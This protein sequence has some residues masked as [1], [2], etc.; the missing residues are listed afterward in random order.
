[1]KN[2][3]KRESFNKLTQNTKDALSIFEKEIR[4]DE[5]RKVLAELKKPKP[6]QNKKGSVEAMKP[7]MVELLEAG[8]SKQNIA[9]ELNVSLA[10][11]NKYLKGM[12]AM[13][14]AEKIKKGIL[15]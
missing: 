6:K 8:Y 1:M 10:T 13:S 11:V 4:E 3:L 12:K 14:K 9:V 15:K 7:Q 5:R 2:N